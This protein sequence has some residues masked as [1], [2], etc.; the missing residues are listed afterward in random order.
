MQPNPDHV[1]CMRLLNLPS[2]LILT[3][4]IEN[5]DHFFIA[6]ENWQRSVPCPD[7]NSLCLPLGMM[8]ALYLNISRF[9]Y[10]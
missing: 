8:F 7:T 9:L 4:I 6:S 2:P 1:L 5:N 3:K 10:S